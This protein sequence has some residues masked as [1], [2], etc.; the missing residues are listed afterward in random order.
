MQRADV[1][2]AARAVED[3]KDSGRR[4]VAIL[5]GV[6]TLGAV[7]GTLL[8]TFVLL[9]RYG[10]RATLWLACAVNLLVAYAARA[11][12]NR[13]S[14][15]V[16]SSA[17]E[18]V[19]APSAGAASLPLPPLWFVLFA[20]ALA[21]L[22]FLLMELVW[23]RML[24]PILGGSTFTFGLILAVAL[25]GIGLGGAGYALWGQRRAPTL[26]GLAA[27]CLLEALAVIAPFALGD[28]IALLALLLRPLA[29]LGFFSYVLGWS[30]G[31][32]CCPCS[33]RRGCGGWPPVCCAGSELPPGRC[34]Y[35]QTGERAQP[36]PSRV[37]SGRSV[38]VSRWRLP[39]P[40]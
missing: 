19:A 38:L 17:A 5:Y 9:E 12:A 2:A 33:R 31:S 22:A 3:D 18:E 13:D 35:I 21:G 32:G 29:A 23:Y 25:L 7:L 34:P 28:R 11:Q 4:H 6:N 20:A 26:Q 16:P 37:A 27:L 36:A 1:V 40:P 10:N 14:A 24:G 15:P 39:S 8:S 30:E